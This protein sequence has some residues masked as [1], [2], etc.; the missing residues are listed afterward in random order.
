MNSMNGSAPH[1]GKMLTRIRTFSM[2]NY[3]EPVK[4]RRQ[5][6]EPNK[7]KQVP[8]NA[9]LDVR[10]EGVPPQLQGQVGQVEAGLHAHHSL[11]PILGNRGTIIVSIRRFVW[12]RSGCR[13]LGWIP[14]RI[15][16]GSRVLMTNNWKKITPEKNLQL[17]KIKYFLIKNCNSLIPRPP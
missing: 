3:Q 9:G 15:Q 12:S 1:L 7:W 5:V 6:A 11:L 14:I 4:P 2:K 10:A 13:I 16:F 8:D 17:K